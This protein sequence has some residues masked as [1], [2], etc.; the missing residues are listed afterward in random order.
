M[1]FWLIMIVSNVDNKFSDGVYD[2][3]IAIWPLILVSTNYFKFAKWHKVFFQY[4]FLVQL[5]GCGQSISRLNLI[6]NWQKVPKNL[7]HILFFWFQQILI[8]KFF[9]PGIFYQV[10]SIIHLMNLIQLAEKFYTAESIS[11][12]GSGLIFFPWWNSKYVSINL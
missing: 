6:K 8:W 10:P 3:S 7:S 9:S 4:S 1:W 11:R 2:Y 12:A 5:R